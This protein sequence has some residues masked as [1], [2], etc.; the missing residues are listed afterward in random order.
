MNSRT[1]ASWIGRKLAF[2]R[3]L[4]RPHPWFGPIAVGLT[5]TAALIGLMTWL[6]NRHISTGNG[7]WKAGQVTQWKVDFDNAPLDP[8]NYLYFP[9]LGTLCRLLDVLGI[10]VGETWRQMATINTI[11]GGIAAGIVYWLVRHLTGSRDIAFVAVLFHLGCAFFLALA[12]GNED[13]MP[14]YTLVL[15]AMAMAAVWFVAPTPMQVVCVAVAFTL[16]WLMEWRMMFPALPPFVLALALSTGT[17]LQRAGRILL[18][19]AAMIGVVLLVVWLWSGHRGATGLPGLLWTGKGTNQA[20][21][22]FSLHKLE[23]LIAGMGEYW[24]GGRFV[25]GVSFAHLGNEWGSAFA[26][27]MLLLMGFA[28][29]LWRERHDEK[30]RT[31]GIIF[32]GTLAAGEVMNAYSQPADPQMQLNVMP[33]LTIAVTLLLARLPASIVGPSTVVVAALVL[34]PISYNIKVFAAVR[35]DDSRRQAALEELERFDP[36]RTIYVYLGTEYMLAWHA[37][38]WLPS[39]SNICNLGPP[40]QAAPKFKW[41]GLSWPM[42]YNPGWTEEQYVAHVK[43]QLDCA[44]DKGYRVIAA[45]SWP[46]FEADLGGWMM[47]LGRRDHGAALAPLL[48]SYRVRPVGGPTIDHPEGYF[49]IT[50]PQ[51][52][53]GK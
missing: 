41:I 40:P 42:I 38:M 14:S 1:G 39:E 29:L 2:Y 22:G 19:L 52:D 53:T 23:L 44:Y 27:Q 32:L 11:F 18:F 51:G 50:R 13:I 8:S 30:L 45:A 26:L 49:E 16:G 43:A 46:R 24:L 7:L 35:G 31:V 17:R 20:W 37:A 6:D 34:L 9:L 4:R 36:A 33:W 15:A 21:A 3:R 5:T 10:Q 12:I 48:Q 47:L 28:L 25:T